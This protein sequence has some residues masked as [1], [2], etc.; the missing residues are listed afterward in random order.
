SLTLFTGMA[1]AT[2]SMQAVESA[3]IRAS[4]LVRSVDAKNLQTLNLTV[5]G[6]V[7]VFVCVMLVNSLYAATAYRRREFG[8]QRLAGATPGQVLRTVFVEGLV[9]TVAGVLCGTVTALAGTVPFTLVRAD[10]LWPHQA[11]GIWQAV[12]AVAAAVVLGTCLLTARRML[13]T[14]A[15]DAVA[16]AV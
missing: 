13:R 14:P 2:L 8:Q 9:V 3:E 4:G 6:I 5:V 16:A 7:V 11:L 1:T 10:V 12:A 15:V